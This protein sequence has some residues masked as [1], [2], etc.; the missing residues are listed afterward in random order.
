MKKTVLVMVPLAVLALVGTSLGQAKPAGAPAGNPYDYYRLGETASSLNDIGYY[1]LIRERLK[2][3]LDEH[4]ALLRKL[5]L[6]A[7]SLA[8]FD[9]L[10]S[11]ALAM[12]FQTEP[13]YSKWSVEQQ[14]RWKEGQAIR[15]KLFTSLEADLA[16]DP[17][18]EFYYW[19]GRASM[20]LGFTV[21]QDLRVGVRFYE[22]NQK[23]LVATY[24]W[25]RDNPTAK[26]LTPEVAARVKSIAD[27]K[28]KVDDP[29]AGLT[30]NDV[31]AMIESAQ[32]IRDAARE[33]A[34]VR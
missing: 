16:K 2:G 25:L 22:E 33:N 20:E 9:A 34:L 12:P 23:R 18:G 7:E 6:G 4:G 13:D 21:P 10:S 30:K 31:D 26:S 11:L 29:L 24:I 14:K 27:L 19:L 1:F 8:T 3:R 17:Q 5:K 32:S 28:A 15:T